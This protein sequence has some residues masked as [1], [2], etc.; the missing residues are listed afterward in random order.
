MTHYKAT[1]DDDVII[2]TQSHIARQLNVERQAVSQAIKGIYH[3]KG[4]KVKLHSKY[5][6]RKKQHILY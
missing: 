1:K 3:C 4:Y 2:G 6:F 5:D